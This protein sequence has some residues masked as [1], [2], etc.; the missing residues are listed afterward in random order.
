MRASDRIRQW[1]R[2]QGGVALVEFACIVP[3][4]LLMYLGGVAVTQG[5]VAA[6]KTTALTHALG[7][8]VAQV[9]DVTTTDAQD[10]FAAAIAMLSPLSSSSTILRMRVSRVYTNSLGRT[11]VD[12]S[13]APTGTNFA[14]TV[15]TNVDTVI[16]SELRFVG[17]TIIVPEVEYD[18]TPIVGSKYV[19]TSIT[20]K[21]AFYLRSRQGVAI[22]LNSASPPSSCPRS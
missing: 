19:G 15:G 21:R 8:L 4:M 22:T 6:R 16:P 14:R 11:C 1:R 5:V 7:D 2:G 9:K 20:M 10:D 13:T 12:W 18:Y 3:V 17:G